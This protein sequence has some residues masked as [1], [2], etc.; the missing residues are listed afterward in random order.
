MLLIANMRTIS[1]NWR[2]Q[3][4]AR[5]AVLDR[6][7]LLPFETKVCLADCGFYIERFLRNARRRAPVVVP[8]VPM[9]DRLTKKLDVSACLV[10]P[11]TDDGF[12]RSLEDIPSH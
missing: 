9:G 4:R 2:Y 10:L 6:V 3:N 5:T 8:V 7:D 12:S 11:S 1:R